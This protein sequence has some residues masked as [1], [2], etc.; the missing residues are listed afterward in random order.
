MANSITTLGLPIGV[1]REDGNSNLPVPNILLLRHMGTDLG[2]ILTDA[3]DLAWLVND[4]SA[5]DRP[6]L[7]NFPLH[8]NLLLSGY[9]LVSTRPLS[10]PRPL[11]QVENAVHLGLT[12]FVLSFLRGYDRQI[13]NIPMLSQLARSAAQE[14]FDDNQESQEAL[15]WTL[16]IGAAGSTFGGLDDAW[17]IPKTAQAMQS[18]GLHAWEDVVRTLVKFPW[19][20][21]VH[22]QAGQALWRR[23]IFHS[24]DFRITGQS[25]T[26]G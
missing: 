5:R 18:L 25:K 1:R 8:D 6:K 2:A 16:F 26:M 14:E 10:R 3:T 23:S 12:A 24:T 7:K 13:P 20:N 21:A 17:L 9:R 11:S 22:D 4:A 15:L 19:V